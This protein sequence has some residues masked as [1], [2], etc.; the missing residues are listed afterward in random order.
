MDT[1]TQAMLTAHDLRPDLADRMRKSLRAS[2]VG[3]Q[4]MADYLGVTRGTISTWINGRIVPS[5][6]TL[7]LWSLRTGVPYSWLRDGERP[8]PVGAGA[9]GEGLPR[10]DLNQRP[11]DYKE[12]QVTPLRKVS[13]TSRARRVERRHGDELRAA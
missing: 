6:Q 4:Q 10:L 12:C 11:S 13:G 1:D 3:V 7:R 8:Q 2:D 5:T 9:S